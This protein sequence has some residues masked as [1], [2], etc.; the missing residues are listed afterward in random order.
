MRSTEAGP[1][2]GVKGCHQSTPPDCGHKHSGR[3]DHLA[4][5]DNDVIANVDADA[6]GER[7]LT[8]AF[9]TRR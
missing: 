7:R 2:S 3:S 4:T 1:T 8:A 5:V 6:I 9:Q